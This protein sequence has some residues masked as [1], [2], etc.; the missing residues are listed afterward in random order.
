MTRP[1]QP[2]PA[3]PGLE[4][5]RADVEEALGSGRFDRAFYE[6]AMRRVTVE[7]G[8]FGDRM[9]VVNAAVR[10]GVLRS[11]DEVIERAPTDRWDPKTRKI[12]PISRSS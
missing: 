4:Q 1:L 2:S 11:A 3:T 12:V 5:L 10:A 6:D 7:R 8:D 9:H